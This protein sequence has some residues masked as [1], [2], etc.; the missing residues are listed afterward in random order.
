LVAAFDRPGGLERT[1][2]VLPEYGSIELA[3][4]GGKLPRDA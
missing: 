2:T 3:Q 4:I 1:T